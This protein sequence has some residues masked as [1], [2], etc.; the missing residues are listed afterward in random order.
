MASLCDEESIEVGSLKPHWSAINNYHEDLGFPG[1]SKG[2]AV[3]SVV[4]GTASNQIE[5][6]VEKVLEVSMG[7]PLALAGEALM[8]ARRLE[9]SE[10]RLDAGEGRFGEGRLEAGEAL[11]FKWNDSL[12]IS[13]K[14]MQ[15]LVE[16]IRA[17]V[18]PCMDNLLALCCSEA[19]RCLDALVL[20]ISAREL[21]LAGCWARIPS[22]ARNR[23][24]IQ[25]E[26]RDSTLGDRWW[27][28][29]WGHPDT[30]LVIVALPAALAKSS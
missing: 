12:R 22:A 20:H 15:V 14:A 18:L 1:R 10:G 13:A 27:A 16:Q 9:A 4:K 2:G 23:M 17:Q 24:G 28:R 30:E 8:Q 11:P 6:A 5:L 26:E 3:T 21:A 29:L 25:L 19:E 7:E